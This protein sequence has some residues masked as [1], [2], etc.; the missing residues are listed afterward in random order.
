MNNEKGVRDALG[1]NERI[2]TIQPVQINTSVGA[3]APNQPWLRSFPSNTTSQLD[4]F[5]HDGNTFGMDGT[6]VSIFE[7]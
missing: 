7:Q 6:Q 3:I 4:I 2:T 1:P 5:W